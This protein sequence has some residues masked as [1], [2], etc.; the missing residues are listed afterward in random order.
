[1]LGKRKV[2]QENLFYPPRRQVTGKQQLLREINAHI[3]FAPFRSAAAPYFSDVGR[4]SIDPIVMAKM[5]FLGYLFG[6]RSDR[7][8]VEE[9]IDRDSF[10]EFVGY[11]PDEDVPIHSNF[12]HWRQKL[13]SQVFKEFLQAILGQCEEAGMRL[14]SCR[15]FDST[16][17]KARA[18][19][20]SSAKVELELSEQPD[21]YLDAFDWQTESEDPKDDPRRGKKLVV[22]LNDP[23]ARLI[24]HGNEPSR[25]VH[26]MHLEVDSATGLI[27]NAMA[28]YRR[29]YEVMLEFL[30]QERRRVEAIGADTGYCA[31]EC[32]REL[33]RLGIKG[34]IPVLDHSN[35]KGDRYHL[36]DFAYRADSDTYTCPA[37]KTL[38]LACVQTKERRRRYQADPNDC[39][40]CPLRGECISKGRARTLTVSD[41][42]ALIERMKL[43]NRLPK[44]ARIM[45]KRKAVMEGTNAHAKVWCGMSQARGIGRDAMDIQGAMTAVVINVKKLIVHLRKPSLDVSGAL[46]SVLALCRHVMGASR[47]LT[48]LLKRNGRSELV[49]VRKP[50]WAS[51]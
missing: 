47:A 17:V 32:Y 5:M 1:M 26:K 31:V 8:I 38:R 6:I 51:L 39:G 27:V 24:R 18:S 43:A 42:R 48:A 13:G 36:R 16:R 4:P 2:R 45:K 14:G 49:K 23:E 34:F 40:A 37:G 12:T 25:F 19:T 44:Y 35:D 9:V 10:R 20:S 41:D 30:R 33:E 21:E 7:A 11:G 3:D 50:S 29:E 28:S 46:Q 22:N 15:L